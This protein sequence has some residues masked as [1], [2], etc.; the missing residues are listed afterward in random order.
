MVNL[1]RKTRVSR[2]ETRGDWTVVHVPRI[3]HRVWI[4]GWCHSRLC[5][6]PGA[7]PAL[8]SRADKLSPVWPQAH[9]PRIQGRSRIR[10]WWSFTFM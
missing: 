2:P 7:V 3:Q 4:R 5:D 10:G 1:L 6:Y 9:D 8:T